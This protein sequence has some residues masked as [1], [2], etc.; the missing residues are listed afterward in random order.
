MRRQPQQ[1]QTR[2]PEDGRHTERESQQGQKLARR[3]LSGPCVR[4]YHLPVTVKEKPRRQ[5][6]GTRLR[7]ATGHGERGPCPRVSTHGPLN[8][9]RAFRFETSASCRHCTSVPLGHG[10]FTSSLRNEDYTPEH[11][12]V[13]QVPTLAELASPV[14][15]T[16]R[17]RSAFR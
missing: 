7:V 1:R 14:L 12:K 4:D 15:G 11:R 17:R 10:S 5:T 16:L 6:N 8:D 3:S 9:P 13:H 2:R